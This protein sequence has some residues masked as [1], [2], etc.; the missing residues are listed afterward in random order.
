VR[1]RT[2]ANPVPR[3]LKTRGLKAKPSRRPR[4]PSNSR[5]KAFCERWLVHHDHGKAAAEA[6]FSE[7]NKSEAGLR[8]LAQFRHYLE[9]MRPK[10]ELQV[11][12][13]LSYERADI[14]DAIAAIGLCNAQD[15]I[16]EF[17]VVNPVTQMVEMRFGLKPLEELTRAQASAIDSMFY[18]TEHGRLGYNLPKAKT[19]LTALNTLGEQ[20]A[21]WKRPA[22]ATHNHL[23]LENLP[24]DKVLAVKKMFVNLIGVPAAREILG[25]VDEETPT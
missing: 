21:N 12:K 17:T 3:A 4:N 24:M 20:Q 14:L 6:G 2:C 7:T 8:K 11:A 1:K 23:H 10:V 19:R 9:R 22:G 13:K 25:Y 18:D 5:D 15:Y 16:K